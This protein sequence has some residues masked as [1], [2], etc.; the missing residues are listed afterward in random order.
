MRK[1]PLKGYCRKESRKAAGLWMD[2]RKIA[3]GSNVQCEI[4]STKE[5]NKLNLGPAVAVLVQVRGL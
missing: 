4:G 5:G 1:Q 3:R 2:V